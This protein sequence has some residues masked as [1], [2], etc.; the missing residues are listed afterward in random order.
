M[1]AYESQTCRIKFLLHMR[2]RPPPPPKKRFWKSR[3]MEMERSLERRHRG[4]RGTALIAHRHAMLHCLISTCHTFDQYE[5][6][7][8]SLLKT[9]IQIRIPYRGLLARTYQ[10][11]ISTR[12]TSVFIHVRVY[13]FHIIIIIIVIIFSVDLYY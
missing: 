12:P 4:K 8:L 1:V 3:N 6:L 13:M 2:F 10:L 5:C 7:T 11:Y 9:T